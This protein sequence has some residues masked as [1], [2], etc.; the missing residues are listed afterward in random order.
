[1][2][3]I[4]FEHYGENE[5]LKI[6]YS[7]ITGKRYGILGTCYLDGEKCQ[8]RSPSLFLTE[9]EAL[10]WCQF[11][12][13]NKVLPSSLN[14]VLSDEFYIHK[15]PQTLLDRHEEVNKTSPKKK[16]AK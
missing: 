16:V 14:Q 13:D 12:T 5:I 6:E 2:R 11:M 4:F 1:M 15:I 9:E 7:I 8:V 3:F 10:S